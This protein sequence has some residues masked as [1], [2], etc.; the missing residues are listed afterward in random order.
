MVYVAGYY[1]LV[2][3]FSAL[4]SL[5][6]YNHGGTW[7]DEDLSGL[8]VSS[9]SSGESLNFSLDCFFESGAS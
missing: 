8:F 2:G 6:F 4:S 5:S 1:G 3:G 9:L 7:L